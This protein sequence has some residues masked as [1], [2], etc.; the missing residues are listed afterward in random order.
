MQSRETSPAPP[1]WAWLLLSVAGAIALT[2]GILYFHSWQN[3]V[4]DL[5]GVPRLRWFSYPQSAFLSVLL[6]FVFVEI[7]QLFDEDWCGSGYDSSTALRRLGFR[8]SWWWVC[9]WHWAS[10]SSMASSFAA[11]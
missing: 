6:L 8:S 9:C 2:I 3:Q 5:M 10:R 11:A 1:R 7:G 4:R